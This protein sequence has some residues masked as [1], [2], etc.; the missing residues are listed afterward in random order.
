[1]VCSKC[2][3]PLTEGVSLFCPECGTPVEKS[4]NVSPI[5]FKIILA[6]LTV[7][8]IGWTVFPFLRAG[9]N[10][11]T[12]LSVLDIIIGK[13]DFDGMKIPATPLLAPIFLIIPAICIFFIFK[14]NVS[15]HQTFANLAIFQIYHSI[16]ISAVWAVLIIAGIYTNNIYAYG[17]GIVLYLCMTLLTAFLAISFSGARR[18]PG[19]SRSVIWITT[20]SRFNLVILVC[21][22]VIL[23]AGVTMLGFLSKMPFFSILSV[24]SLVSGFMAYIKIVRKDFTQWMLLSIHTIIT[25]FAQ[26]LLIESATRFVEGFTGEIDFLDISGFVFPYIGTVCTV[27]LVFS[28]VYNLTFTVWSYKQL[29]RKKFRSVISH[30]K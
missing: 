18:T 11:I 30:E 21:L 6:V 13:G 9:G 28:L 26:L 23:L 14:K 7:L 22:S 19:E 15:L 16:L 20:A 17:F 3:C 27:V 2:G 24:L 8:S 12:T 29:K 4:K 5:V 1:M 10:K 25:F